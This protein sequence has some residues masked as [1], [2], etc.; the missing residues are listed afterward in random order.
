MRG[1]V[2]GVSGMDGLLSWTVLPPL[3][4]TQSSSWLNVDNLSIQKLKVL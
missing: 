4:P 2:A 1:P 3:H